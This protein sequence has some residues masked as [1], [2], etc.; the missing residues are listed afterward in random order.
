M[1]NV[2]SFLIAVCSL[3]NNSWNRREFLPSLSL[4]VSSSFS[5]QT[6]ADGHTKTIYGDDLQEE[7]TTSSQWK[8]VLPMERFSGGTNCIRMSIPGEPKRILWKSIRP[9]RVYR[10]IVDTGSPYLTIPNESTQQSPYFNTV[11]EYLNEKSSWENDEKFSFIKASLFDVLFDSLLLDEIDKIPFELSSSLYD[12][13]QDIYGSQLGLID[14]KKSSI[15]F[16]NNRLMPCIN[17]ET[18]LKERSVV[19]GA[20]DQSLTKESG[21]PLIGLVKNSNFASS[22]NKVQLRPTFL[23]QIR[24]LPI[25][26]DE[27]EREIT[28]FQIDSPNRK[29][30]L[31]AQSNSS[32]IPP[33]SMKNIIELI[34]LRPL[35]DFIDHY[36]FVVDKLSL[37]HGDSHYVITS[38][39]LSHDSKNPRPIV[40]VFDTGLTGCLL[41]QPLWDALIDTVGLTDPSNIRSLEVLKIGNHQERMISIQ[42]DAS[43]NP[44][45][46][47][48]SINLDW[49]N[50]EINSPFVV[51][52]GQTFLSQGILTIDIELRQATFELS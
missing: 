44:F 52:L 12:P 24:M 3:A 41:T 35:G 17:E 29:F 13:T 25:N 22:S 50:D 48:S 49:F 30:T 14:W 43:K 20:L 46:Y 51:V 40:A 19:L 33:N 32:L 15:I 28:S 10:L 9:T 2:V 4:L 39:E 6:K 7:P 37:N 34:D 5:D 18:H 42:S 8:V 36:A 1:N 47:V 23:D 11:F 26:G 38:K 45:Y 27:S 16:R 31:L 21:G